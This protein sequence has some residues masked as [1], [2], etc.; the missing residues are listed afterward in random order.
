MARAVLGLQKFS[1]WMTTRSAVGP[2]SI[3]VRFVGGSLMMVGKGGQSRM[4]AAQQAALRDWLGARFCRSTVKIR[5]Y[6]AA[7]FSILYAH[8][9]CLKMP[10]RL[11]F[12]CRKPRALPH[13]ANSET[14]AE[15][16][17]FY[18]DWMTKLPADE[19]VY[20][21]DAVHPEHQT[22][23]AF[24]WVRKGSN[25]AVK[26]S[27]GRGRVNIHGGV[28]LEKFDAP[29]IKPVNV[30]G[31][32]AV[33]LLAKIEANTPK[34]IICPSDLAQCSRPPLRGSQKMALTSEMPYPSDPV[35]RILP[36][37]EP[38]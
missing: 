25:P 12:E 4:M 19:A 36:T 35:S 31:D 8:S 32:N 22:K 27:A 13:V 21:S 11:G 23:P 26:T 20:F 24:G 30:G 18:Q 15:F 38:D 37:P 9:G 2:I 33:Q 29:F 16:I 5:A 17:V 3:T 7:E 1:A 6:I 14:H 34:Q 10:G 28:Y